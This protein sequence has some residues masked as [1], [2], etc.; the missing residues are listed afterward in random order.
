VFQEGTAGSPARVLNHISNYLA[1][2]YAV[3]DLNACGEACQEYAPNTNWLDKYTA[4]PIV[5]YRSSI[6]AP[7]TTL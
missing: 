4:A 7:C 6:H 1:M 5:T 2:Q 3:K